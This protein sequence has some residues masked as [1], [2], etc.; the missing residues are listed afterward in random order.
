MERI[1]VIDDEPLVLSAVQKALQMVGY[2][3]VAA[4][5]TETCLEALRNKGPFHLLIMD[6]HL[7]GIGWKALLQEARQHYPHIKVIFMSG[8]STTPDEGHFLLKP[9]RIQELRELVR[10]TLDEPPVGN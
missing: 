3:V 5:D 9:F 1:L 2:E 6:L 10:K 7:P 8:S 4:P